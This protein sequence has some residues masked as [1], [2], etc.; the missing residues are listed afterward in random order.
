MRSNLPHVNP[1]Y[2]SSRRGCVQKSPVGEFT[3][4]MRVVVGPLAK[5]GLE[6][7]VGPD[8]PAAVNAALVY[9]V[10]RLSSGRGP[11]GFPTFLAMEGPELDVE[12]DERIEAL[13][14]SDAERQGVAPGE[15]AGHGIL[16]YLAE[17]DLVGEPETPA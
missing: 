15:L 6:S 3:S 1:G 5:S 13:L 11:V 16:V 10:G 2:P 17:L 8:L 9:Y 14:C 4:W 12:V 7:R